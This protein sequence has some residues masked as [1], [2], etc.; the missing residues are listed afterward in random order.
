[1]LNDWKRN[2][3]VHSQ[4]S[5]TLHVGQAAGPFT[6][7]HVT[8]EITGVHLN[9][10]TFPKA[11][12]HWLPEN[13]VSVMTAMCTRLKLN[14]RPRREKK[15]VSYWL[16]IF[17]S[18][19]W[20]WVRSQN[21]DRHHVCNHT[22]LMTRRQKW[23]RMWFW[24]T[25]RL[26]ANLCKCLWPCMVVN[27]HQYDVSANNSTH[28]LGITPDTRHHVD[29]ANELLE[30]SE[31]RMSGPDAFGTQA[32]GERHFPDRCIHTSLSDQ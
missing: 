10:S 12:R 3:P 4:S 15:S 8:R 27:S 11:L 18:P 21:S 28:L 23:Q 29:T 24:H 14:Q 9:I 30:P 32:C 19:E 20:R 26:H 2:D 13:L 1:M 17:W 31:A 5:T 6:D 16:N 22:P 25:A 7:A